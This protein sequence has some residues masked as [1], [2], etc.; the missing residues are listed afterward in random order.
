M[1]TTLNRRDLLGTAGTRTGLIRNN[2]KIT[3]GLYCVGTPDE[4]SQVLVTANYKLTVDS[5]RKELGKHNLWILVVD[6]RGINVWCAGGKG[7]FSA[8]EV[9]YQVQRA[10]LEK[11]VTHRKLILPQLSA[12]GVNAAALKKLC[13]FR[14]SFGPIRAV[15]LDRY[16]VTG[17]A[18]EAMRSVTFSYRERAALIPLE[19]CMVWKPLL[20]G[21]LIF[22][23]L[24]GIAPSFF[25]LSSSL[26]RGPVLLGATL[27]AILFGAAFVPL[28]LPLIPSRRF[29]IKGILTGC[30][31]G[32]LYIFLTGA[33]GNLAE[34]VALLLWIMGC[35]SY[36]AMNFTGSTTY[37]S[38]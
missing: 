18:D 38:L 16:L 22:F 9:S 6:T 33:G 30:T 31:G 29:W 26:S 3:P 27:V 28:L 15:D 13:G 21:T 19:L 32:M 20:I 37:T 35:S 12:N 7:T 14:G 5:L 24:S 8:E 1:K 25:S 34:K 10:N 2:Y 17:K 4:N 11:V 36:L 23:F